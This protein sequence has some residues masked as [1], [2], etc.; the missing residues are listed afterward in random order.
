MYYT[1]YIYFDRRLSERLKKNN[2]KK[3]IYTALKREKKTADLVEGE[4]PIER[5]ER[6][7]PLYPVAPL[8]SACAHAFW[9]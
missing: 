4:K 7:Y 1:I 3:R 9:N 8:S 5:R 2:E 6:F